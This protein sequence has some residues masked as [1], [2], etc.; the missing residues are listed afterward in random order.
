MTLHDILGIPMEEKHVVSLC[1]AGGK[2]TLMYALARECREHM[3]TAIFTT[4]HIF[5]PSGEDFALLRPF[6]ETECLL[7]WERKMIVSAGTPTEDGRKFGPPEEPASAFLCREGSAVIIEADGSRRMPLKYPGPWEPVI[8]PETT[9]VVVVAGLSALGRSPEEAIHRLALARD[10]MDIPDAPVDADA[11]AE[12]MWRG[13]GRFSPVFL[14][15]Q[16]DTPQLRE[17]G[18]RMAYRLRK[19]GAERTAVLALLEFLNK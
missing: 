10:V 13:Y 19:L 16:A 5:P 18:E 2:T 14:L 11:A 1:G 17:Q 8:R 4:T 3:P 12:L 7:A 15:N 6:S 9:H